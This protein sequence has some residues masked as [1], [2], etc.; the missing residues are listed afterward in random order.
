MGVFGN[1]LEEMNPGEAI[2][3]L[4][5]M[6]RNENWHGQSEFDAMGH[7]VPMFRRANA[8]QH[9]LDMGFTDSETRFSV[10]NDMSNQIARD[11][12]HA[13]MEHAFKKGVDATGVYRLLAVLLTGEPEEPTP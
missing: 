2:P 6:K 10:I 12:T 3:S 7:E 13:A 4:G 1:A 9:M 8:E 5:K 11:N